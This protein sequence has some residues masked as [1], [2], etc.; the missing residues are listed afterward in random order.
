MQAVYG[1]VDE[2]DDIHRPA[3]RVLTSTGAGEDGL[4]RYEGDLSLERAG[5]FGFT[6]RV[7]PHPRHAPRN[8]DL[9][10]VTTA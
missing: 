7:L 5:S 2:S 4:L 1:R 3:T 8:S 9:A 10:L 6:V